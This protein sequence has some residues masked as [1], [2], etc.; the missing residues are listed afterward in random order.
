MTEKV[1]AA[2]DQF[3]QNR[4]N[5]RFGFKSV[6]PDPS[7]FAVAGCGTPGRSRDCRRTLVLSGDQVLQVVLSIGP[8]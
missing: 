1:R 7:G 3:R 8:T 5:G 2:R 4:S 6:K